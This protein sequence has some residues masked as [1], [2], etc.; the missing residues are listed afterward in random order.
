MK[1]GVPEKLVNVMIVDDDPLIRQLYKEL[2]SRANYEIIG[3]AANG[4]EALQRFKELEEQIDLILM[5]HKMPK[6]DGLTVAQ[7]IIQNNPGIKILMITG[8]ST[9]NSKLLLECGIKHR[10]KPINIKEIMIAIEGL[11]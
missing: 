8:D 1:N 6:K 4:D 7:E 5:D 11:V 3:E 9:L 2:L 10:Q